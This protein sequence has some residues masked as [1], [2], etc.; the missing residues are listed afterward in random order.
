LGEDLDMTP[1]EIKKAIKAHRQDTSLQLEK[2]EEI[3]L[4]N[5]EK[6]VIIDL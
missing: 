2:I 3:G 6:I 1:D 5:G 4:Q